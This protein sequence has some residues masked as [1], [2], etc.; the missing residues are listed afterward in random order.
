VSIEEGNGGLDHCIQLDFL[1]TYSVG[2]G[3]L[4]VELQAFTNLVCH[5]MLW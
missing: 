3:F 1:R 2:L 5:A 4:Y